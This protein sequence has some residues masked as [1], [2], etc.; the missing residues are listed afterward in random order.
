LRRIPRVGTRRSVCKGVEG[1]LLERYT[2][3]RTTNSP[4]Q[5]RIIPHYRG[6][7]AS[8]QIV[9]KRL[10]FG[11]SPQ[12]IARPAFKLAHALP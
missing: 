1:T 6:R 3:D 8:I 9:I 5:G 10:F 4:G 7:T 12:L 2:E 11:A